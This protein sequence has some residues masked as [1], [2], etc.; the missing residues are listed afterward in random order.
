MGR[1]RHR[2]GDRCPSD[3]LWAWGSQ[4]WQRVDTSR[5]LRGP[6]L[7][8]SSASTPVGANYFPTSQSGKLRHGKTSEKPEVL[9]AE[10]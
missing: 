4:W 10:S 9:G 1:G 2:A 7:L 5:E 3:A 6:F 8:T